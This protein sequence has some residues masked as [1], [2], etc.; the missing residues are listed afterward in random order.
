[1]FLFVKA[2]FSSI[3][4]ELPALR[5]IGIRGQTR[6]SFV[7]PLCPGCDDF[8]QIVIKTAAKPLATSMFLNA[9]VA[10]AHWPVSER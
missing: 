3:G 6:L 5:N 7:L 10:G 2:L 1:M 4:N 8:C 9:G